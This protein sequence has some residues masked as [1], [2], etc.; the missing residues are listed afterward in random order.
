ML[1]ERIDKKRLKKPKN[2]KR[3]R[4][5]TIEKQEYLQQKGEINI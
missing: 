4:K 2:M 5:E 3:K 1:S